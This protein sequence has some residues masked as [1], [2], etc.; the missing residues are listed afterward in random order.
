MQVRAHGT[1]IVAKKV[2]MRSSVS[3]MTGKEWDW[4]RWRSEENAEITMVLGK[5]G[6]L[7]TSKSA[8]QASKWGQHRKHCPSHSLCRV[9]MFVYTLECIALALWAIAKVKIHVHSSRLIQ[10]ECLACLPGIL[11]GCWHWAQWLP[12]GWLGIPY[13]SSP[14]QPW[15]KPKVILK[16]VPLNCCLAILSPMF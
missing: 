3:G 14:S 12:W 7:V 1:C 9:K 16:L 2:R 10:G 15:L 5:L 8:P 4:R 6:R 13:P 11:P